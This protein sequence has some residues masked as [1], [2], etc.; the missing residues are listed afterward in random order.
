MKLR[1]NFNFSFSLVNS[2]KETLIVDSED[3]DIIEL[4]YE[5]YELF[6]GLKEAL[7]KKD[8]FSNIICNLISSN[9]FNEIKGIIFEKFSIENDPKNK[10]IF[11][12][13]INDYLLIGP[14]DDS[15][16]FGIKKNCFSF[17]RPFDNSYSDEY[18]NNFLKNCLKEFC[19]NKANK[20]TI[21]NILY[22]D[23]IP[24][25]IDRFEVNDQNNFELHFYGTCFN[26]SRFEQSFTIDIEIKFQLKNINNMKEIC[27]IADKVPEILKFDLAKKIIT[28]KGSKFSVI[29]YLSY[30]NY[31]MN[32]I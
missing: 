8:A 24:V 5:D 1:L 25:V 14:K 32:N 15:K 29:F 18:I 13:A 9:E 26:V 2:L 22:K 6:E 27:E 28:L 23:D 7:R 17:K 20:I 19:I 31:V 3:I 30:C 21:N 10:D 11:L 4:F 16:I 12:K